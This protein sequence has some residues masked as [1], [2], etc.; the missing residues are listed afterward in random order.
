M[1]HTLHGKS[2]YKIGGILGAS[3][4]SLLMTAHPLRDY[5]HCAGGKHRKLLA[6]VLP[7]ADSRSLSGQRQSAAEAVQR[8]DAQG[9]GRARF[10]PPSH[11]RAW[12]CTTIVSRMM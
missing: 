9:L 7:G 10:G 6:D 12:N 3:G 8:A 5:C 1:G 4:L 2:T 11:S